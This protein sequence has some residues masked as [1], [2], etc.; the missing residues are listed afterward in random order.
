MLGQ[1]QTHKAIVRSS[2]VESLNASL[3]NIFSKDKDK[4]QTKPNEEA[5]VLRLKSLFTMFK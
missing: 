1:Y 3:V 2:T 4:L 5:S